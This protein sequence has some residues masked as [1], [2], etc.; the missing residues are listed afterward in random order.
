MNREYDSPLRDFGIT[1]APNRDVFVANQLPHSIRTFVKRT[2]SQTHLISA[3]SSKL[4]SYQARAAP[5]S[6]LIPV[7]NAVKVS[8]RINQIFFDIM[9]SQ[10]EPQSSRVWQDAKFSDS[11]MVD[12]VGANPTKYIFFLGAQGKEHIDS[13]QSQIPAVGAGEIAVIL[14]SYGLHSCGKKSGDNEVRKVATNEQCSELTNYFE[15]RDPL[16]GGLY[17]LDYLVVIDGNDLVRCKIPLV[18][19][20][21][22]RFQRTMNSKKSHSGISTHLNFG[23]ELENLSGFLDE[24]IQYFTKSAR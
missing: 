6:T 23:I 14:V 11:M 10:Q 2:N 3:K 7:T 15:M 8:D 13:I 12:S 9:L 1:R 22:N 24:Y 21:N 16:G 5:P 20:K 4:R 17:P 18:T 19:N